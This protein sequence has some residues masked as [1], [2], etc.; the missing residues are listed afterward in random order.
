MSRDAIESA[1][2]RPYSGFGRRALFP[3][4]HQKAAA[5]VHALIKNHGF[6]D[7]NKRTAVIAVNVLLEHS[8][9][10]LNASNAEVEWMAITVADSK[11]DL[12]ALTDWFQAHIRRMN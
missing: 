4:I 12:S 6:I 7:G 10:E 5:L 8:G 1:I 3:R 11:L 2:A 9:Y